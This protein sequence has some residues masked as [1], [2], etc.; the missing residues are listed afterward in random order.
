[1]SPQEKLNANIKVILSQMSQMQRT[2]KRR[3][4]EKETKKFF[5]QI[6]IAAEVKAKVEA[7]KK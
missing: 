6:C 7:I 4:F 5:R 2:S 1:M 3:S